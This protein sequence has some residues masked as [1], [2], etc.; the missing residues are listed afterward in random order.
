LKGADD[1]VANLDELYNTFMYP[2]EVTVI[3][4]ENLPIKDFVMADVS[5]ETTCKSG[6]GKSGI[7]IVICHAKIDSLDT[8]A[9]EV[10]GP[11]LFQL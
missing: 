7:E 11:T 9:L 3:D 5:N 2:P 1:L 10:L 4:E 6:L 8:I